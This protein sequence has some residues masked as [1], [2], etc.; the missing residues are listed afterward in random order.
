MEN[1]ISSINDDYKYQKAE[2]PVKRIAWI[3][4][5]IFLTL[6]IAGLFGDDDA[7][8]NKKVINVAGIDVEY[9]RFLRVEKSFEMKL[10]LP[11]SASNCTISL[12]KEYCEKVR[13]TEIMPAPVS[14]EVN[15]NKIIYKFKAQGGG[16]ITFFMDPIIRG[17]S[18][19]EI[20]VN[21]SPKKLS[22]F[23]YF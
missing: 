2:W 6:G 11:D 21:G 22:Q 13:I 3:L 4:M 7:I 5:G 23:I 8:L 19:F 18:N 15:N 16:T 12:N 17:K 1:D 9:E 14:Q 20:G 10:Y